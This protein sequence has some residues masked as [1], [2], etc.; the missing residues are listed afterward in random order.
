MKKR[1]GT[2]RHALLTT[3]S[4][5]IREAGDAPLAQLDRASG[6]E[7]G[8]RKFESCRAHQSFQQLT[9]TFSSKTAHFSHFR[10]L[11]FAPESANSAGVR[12]NVMALVMAPCYDPRP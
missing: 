4:R 8:G 12:A 11:N 1:T 3:G 6:Y 9:A 5:Y 10:S 7:P 2:G